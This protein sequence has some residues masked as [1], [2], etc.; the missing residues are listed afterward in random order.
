M[1]KEL[2]HLPI[3][4]RDPYLEPYE[5]ALIGRAEDAARKEAEITGG[6]D[7]AKWASGYLY[8]GLHHDRKNKQW[9]LREWAPNAT[10]IYIKG[11][12]TD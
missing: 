8:F 12:M 2:K 5:A 7:L 3:V 9:I 1:E 11:D 10:A 6:E 4:A